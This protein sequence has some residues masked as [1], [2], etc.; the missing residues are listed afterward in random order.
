MSTTKREWQSISLPKPMIKDI[1]YILKW[2]HYWSSVNEFCREA[3][4]KSIRAHM[5]WA[6]EKEEENEKMPHLAKTELGVKEE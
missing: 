3:V 2:V 1:K 6:L 5:S 4:R